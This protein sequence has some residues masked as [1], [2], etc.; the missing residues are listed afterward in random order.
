MPLK[1]LTMSRFVFATLALSLFGSSPSAGEPAVDFNRDVRHVLADNCFK[2]HGPDEKER[3]AKLRLDDR[4]VAL[5]R[6]AF[7][8][9]E[10]AQ[11]KLIARITAT[12]PAK[13]MPPAASG[14]KLTSQQIELLKRWIDQ[15]AKY[16]VHWAF[17]PPQRPVV[18]TAGGNPAARQSGARQ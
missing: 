2:C 15:G 16:S 13:R 14:K 4:S 18:P 8:P 3:K 17:V 6:E 10:S 7:V 12:D 11:S 1:R 5:P 9:G